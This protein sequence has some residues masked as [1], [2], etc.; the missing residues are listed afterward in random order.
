MRRQLVKTVSEILEQDSRVVLLLGDI[1]VFGFRELF[2]KF[3]NRVYNIGILEQASVGLAAGLSIEGMIPIFHTIAPFIVERALEQLKVDFGYQ[4]LVGNF[5]SVGASYDYASLGCTHHC[6]GDVQILKTIPGMKIMVPGHPQEFDSLFRKTYDKS[7]NYFRL[8]ERSNSKPF[9]ECEVVKFGNQATVIAIG[10]ML[11]RVIEACQNLDVTVL[12]YTTVAPFKELDF[13]DDIAVVES[14]Y[15]KDSIVVVEPFYEGTMTYD[16]L[17]R[18]SRVLS[19]GVPRQF[20]NSYGTRDDFDANYGLTVD[21]IHEK[22]QRW[23]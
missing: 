23:L 7:L 13:K 8:S 4:G 19:I 10:P 5:I 18:K 16:V 22:I 9:D 12:Y 14:F 1:G 21:A 17:K 20:L 6:P 3:P 15:F 2:K 11:D